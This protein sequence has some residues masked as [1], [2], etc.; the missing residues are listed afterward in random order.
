L[1]GECNPDKFMTV[2]QAIEDQTKVAANLLNAAFGV[3]ILSIIFAVVSSI[4]LIKAYK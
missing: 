1:N 2:P 4:V 3:A